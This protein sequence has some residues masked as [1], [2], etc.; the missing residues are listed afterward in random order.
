M[1]KVTFRVINLNCCRD[2]R[3]GL[4]C[5]LWVFSN[6]P[7]QSFISHVSCHAWL[8][9]LPLPPFCCHISNI[10]VHAHFAHFC[11][12]VQY[13]SL[14]IYAHSWSAAH[15]EEEKSR[16]ITLVPHNNHFHMFE[17]PT[18][19]LPLAFLLLHFPCCSEDEMSPRWV[20]M[21]VSKETGGNKEL[22]IQL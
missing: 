9:L 6:S 5:C 13:R 18:T 3:F 12:T 17:M 19:T 15:R 4:K 1:C 7:I 14:D 11:I 21:T 10:S 22:V 20:D 2:C 8:Q 16:T